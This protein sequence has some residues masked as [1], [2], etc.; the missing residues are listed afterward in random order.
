M[1]KDYWCKQKKH[2]RRAEFFNSWF[3]ELIEALLIETNRLSELEAYS[4]V[5]FSLTVLYWLLLNNFR[6]CS[7]NCRNIHPENSS[8][9][10]FSLESEKALF[11][12]Y[13]LRMWAYLTDLDSLS[14]ETEHLLL[15]LDSG[16][17][18]NTYAL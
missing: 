7:W 4:L 2:V 12:V 18:G 16:R 1:L 14:S 11:A 8:I 6:Q 15:L 13:F 10:S 9:R 3:A 17:I 5:Y